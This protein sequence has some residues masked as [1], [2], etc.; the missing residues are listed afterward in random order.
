MREQALQLIRSLVTAGNTPDV[1]MANA[2]IT[3]R[4]V[5]LFGDDVDPNAVVEPAV[6][7]GWLENE[8]NP[9]G[10]ASPTEAGVAAAC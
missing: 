7:E 3:A 2:M 8:N 10:W 4:A 1:P 9:P 6:R 5:S